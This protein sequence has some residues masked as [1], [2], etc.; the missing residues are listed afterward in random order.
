MRLALRFALG[1][2]AI[3]LIPLVFL[4]RHLLDLSSQYKTLDYIK[5]SFIHDAQ[6][7]SPS[8]PAKPGD[9]IIVMARTEQENTDWVANY[10]PE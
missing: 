5:T 3:V 6:L 8:F 2:S 7:K 4:T 9:K 1:I 10:L